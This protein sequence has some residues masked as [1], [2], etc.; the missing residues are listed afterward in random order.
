[1][2]ARMIVLWVL[3]L[4]A[5]SV[6]VSVFVSVALPIFAEAPF[7]GRIIWVS[8]RDGTPDLYTMDAEGKDIVRLT[9]DADREEYPKVSPDKSGVAFISDRS[10]KRELWVMALSGGEP[11]QLTRSAEGLEVMEP[12]W[13]PDGRTIAYNVISLNL[14]DPEAKSVVGEVW[15]MNRDGSSTERLIESPGLHFNPVYSADGERLLAVANDFTTYFDHPLA[16]FLFDA[17][18]GGRRR[19]T[20][21]FDAHVSWC[22]GETIVY[23][24]FPADSTVTPGI[25]RM[26]IDGGEPV[27]LTPP[28]W[29]ASPRLPNADPTGRW[30]VFTADPEDRPVGEGEPSLVHYDVYKLDLESGKLTPLTRDE[31]LDEGAWWY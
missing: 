8:H 31:H 13:S 28:E 6:S 17:E 30:L 26:S 27:R 21:G 11:R 3:S 20:E 2:S 14:R 5:V 16:P 29:T 4:L 24:N 19:L 1:M 25:W 15:R 7:A 9:D 10:G 23:V 22:G 12:D 18:G